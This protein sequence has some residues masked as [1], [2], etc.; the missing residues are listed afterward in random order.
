M[1]LFG[2]RVFVAT[3]KVKI[4]K[5][6]HCGLG[7]TLNPI[8][9]GLK[10]TSKKETQARG[11]QCEDRGR[12]Q[13]DVAASQELLAPTARGRGTD[14]HQASR[15]NQHCQHLGFGLQASRTVK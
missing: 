3:I 1:T 15:R 4:S 5:C 11:R 6:N 7:P 2:I 12:D 10:K 8:T 9:R 13:S 14:S